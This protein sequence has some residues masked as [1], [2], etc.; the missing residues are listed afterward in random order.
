[1]SFVLVVDGIYR[2][3]GCGIFHTGKIKCEENA[4]IE[5]KNGQPLTVQLKD[6][7][8]AARDGTYGHQ[9]R[10]LKTGDNYGFGLKTNIGIQVGDEVVV[11]IS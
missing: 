9:T 11:T 3:R 7:K 10:M 6:K 4:A 1:M 5:I 2:I 8:S